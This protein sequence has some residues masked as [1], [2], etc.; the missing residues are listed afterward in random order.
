M[1]HCTSVTP[2]LHP[3]EWRPVYKALCIIRPKNTECVSFVQS[4]DTVILVWS[5]FKGIM[6][7]LKFCSSSTEQAPV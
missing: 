6:L 4:Y 2:S 1:A 5:N 7:Y 3:Y